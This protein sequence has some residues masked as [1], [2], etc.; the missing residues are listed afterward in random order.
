MKRVKRRYLALQLE[1][2]EEASQREFLDT[3]WAA[4]TTLYGEHGASQTGLALID[5]NDQ[6]KTALIR[7]SL[8]M[9]QQVRASLA[10]VTQINGKEAAI[11]VVAISGTIKSL[12]KNIS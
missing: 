5:F 4:I 11:H 7:V 6:K 3:V 12:K 9:L 8:S 2:E 1:T 10:S